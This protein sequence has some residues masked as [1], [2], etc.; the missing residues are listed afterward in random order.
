MKASALFRAL[1]PWG[2][3][4]TAAGLLVLVLIGLQGLGFRWDPLGLDQ[5]RLRGAEARASE[6]T[7]EAAARR[8]EVEAA[9]GQARR[10]DE[11]HQQTVAV[12][13]ATAT[14]AQRARISHDAAEPLDPARAARLR[15]HDRE[16]CRLAPA[17]C[18][19]APAPAADGGDQALHPREAAGSTD[20]GGS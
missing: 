19:A 15:E 4:A 16:L 6:A 7:A 12:A 1:T 13:Q 3:T 18:G 17:V 10:I 11:L 14:T 5:R 9:A 8:A 20:P 2:W